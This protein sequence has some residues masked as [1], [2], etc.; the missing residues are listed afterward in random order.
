M[1]LTIIT[2]IFTSNDLYY[3]DNDLITII[4]LIVGFNTIVTGRLLHPLVTNIFAHLQ[5]QLRVIIW[6]ILLFQTTQML[7]MIMIARMGKVWRLP[8]I[9]YSPPDGSEVG[10]TASSSGARRRVVYM[11]YGWR[12][13]V[14]DREP[15]RHHTP[16]GL[17]YRLTSQNGRCLW[18]K[19]RVRR[20]SLLHRSRKRLITAPW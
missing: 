7:L 17:Y 20:R 1:F 16:M 8:Y 12:Y 5:R 4:C 13:R 18:F 2:S 3:H 6:P 14:V 15:R 10:D 11:Q 9:V 19:G